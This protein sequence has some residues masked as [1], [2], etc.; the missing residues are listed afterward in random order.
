MRWYRR[1]CAIRDELTRSNSS[2]LVGRVSGYIAAI[3]LAAEVACP[4]LGLRFKPDVIGP[5]LM[6]HLDEQQRDQN[7]TCL[8]LAKI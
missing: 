5:W 1:F 6:L 8:F 4:L 7:R 3:Q 2:N